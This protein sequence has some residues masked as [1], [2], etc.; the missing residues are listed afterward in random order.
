MGAV[1]VSGIDERIARSSHAARVVEN[2][3]E[4]DRCLA[5]GGVRTIRP[6]AI[7][8]EVNVDCARHDWTTVV[9]DS[10][11]GYHRRVRL[12]FRGRD[13]YRSFDTPTFAG[14]N[15]V[16]CMTNTLRV[17]IRQKRAYEHEQ[18]KRLTHLDPPD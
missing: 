15:Y 16:G 12:G 17:S 4:T 14:W 8:D 7:P 11:A 5:V 3:H 6:I 18:Q 9:V 2:I 10:V 13:T 1:A